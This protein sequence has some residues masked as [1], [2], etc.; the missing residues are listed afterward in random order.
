MKIGLEKR[1]TIFCTLSSIVPFFDA[2]SD[3]GQQGMKRLGSSLLTK[4]THSQRSEPRVTG[5]AGVPPALR[6][7]YTGHRRGDREWQP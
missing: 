4:I 2:V 6:P 3:A 7:L 1:L 5:S